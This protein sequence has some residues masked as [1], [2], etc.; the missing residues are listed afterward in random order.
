MSAAAAAALDD[1][2][3]SSDDFVE[4][5]VSAAKVDPEVAFAAERTIPKLVR[6]VDWGDLDVSRRATRKKGYLRGILEY[7]PISTCVL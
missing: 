6:K 4:S 3:E 5:S 2:E 1:F 7:A